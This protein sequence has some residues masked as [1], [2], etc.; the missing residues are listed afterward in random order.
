MVNFN[1]GK[2]FDVITVSIDPREGP[3]LAIAK[4]NTFIQRYRRPGAESGWHFL[5]GDQKNIT[6][7]ASAAGFGYEYDEASGQ[8]A[9]ATAIMVLTPDG[10]ISRYLYG[11]D[12]PPKDLRL[13]LVEASQ[14][15]IGGVV[16]QILLYCYHYNPATGKYGAIIT[17]VLRIAGGITVLIVGAFVFVM[18]ASPS[19]LI[20][21]SAVSCH[22]KSGPRSP[23][24]GPELVQAFREFKSIWDPAWKMNPGKLVEPYKMDENLRLGADYDPWQPQ[25]HFQFPEDRG[26]LAAATLRCV[27]VG[28][29]RRYEGGVMQRAEYT[30]E[31][32]AEVNAKIPL[33]RHALPEEI[34]AL[35][36]FL[37]SDDA[38]YIT[39]HVYT[40]D[41]AEIAG[42]LASR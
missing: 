7:L 19:E 32:F 11:V 36:A 33:R 30:D 38:A 39:G 9:H 6:A 31:M 27:G 34:A 17:N 15:K 8:F 42:G 29:C 16:D 22:L 24:F 25:T 23:M 20:Q 10:K 4:K 14:H 18:N 1:I 35:F 37:A 41:G 3:D 40:C 21:M 26:S 28:K 2:E 12:Y 5:T 13:A